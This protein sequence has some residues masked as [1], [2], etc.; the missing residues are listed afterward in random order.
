[1]VF[2]EFILDGFYDSWVASMFSI[3]QQI[4]NKCLLYVNKISCKK[5][6]IIK[7]QI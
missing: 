5:K 7:K 2:Y 3:L 1:M 4:E 6:H